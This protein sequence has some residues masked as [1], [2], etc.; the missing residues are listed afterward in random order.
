[1]TKATLLL[2]RCMRH[3]QTSTQ[4]MLASRVACFHNNPICSLV[5][6]LMFWTEKSNTEKTTYTQ[7]GRSP[8]NYTLFTLFTWEN[9]MGIQKNTF[10]F[11]TTKMPLIIFHFVLLLTKRYQLY[12][13]QVQNAMPF[14]KIHWL[15]EM[16]L[17]FLCDG[18]IC[19]GGKM[20]RQIHITFCIS[21]Q[22]FHII[23]ISHLKN[24]P[25][26]FRCD[27]S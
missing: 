7:S 27:K 17:I 16:C 3:I 20:R 18:H 5:L 12:G 23:R 24:T 10:S 1:M 14:L 15:S 8:E 13:E 9:E 2:H 25:F 4:T 19:N 6:V 21:R 11:F 26:K 22:W